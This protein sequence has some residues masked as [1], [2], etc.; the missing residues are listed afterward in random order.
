MVYIKWQI[1]H[2]NK[3][4]N[5]IAGLKQCLCLLSHQNRIHLGMNP[6][7]TAST[8]KSRCRHPFYAIYSHLINSVTVRSELAP[9]LLRSQKLPSIHFDHLMFA[10]FFFFFFL[11]FQP[12]LNLSKLIFSKSDR[13]FYVECTTL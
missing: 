6:S 4:L 2:L 1:T 8:R 9:Y 11:Q 12:T 10:N 3:K 5:R 13:Y 7:P